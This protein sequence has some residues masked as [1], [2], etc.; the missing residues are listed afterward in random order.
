MSCVATLP[1]YYYL[2]YD[3]PAN[4]C[5]VIM[6]SRS[7]AAS[8]HCCNRVTKMHARRP[9]PHARR[10][11]S[12]S[13]FGRQARGKGRSTDARQKGLSFPVKVEIQSLS[14][15]RRN[16]IGPECR[17]HGIGTGGR[18]RILLSSK[19]MRQVF[20]HL[21]FSKDPKDLVGQGRWVCGD[22]QQM[23]ASTQQTDET[24]VSMSI[25]ICLIGTN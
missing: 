15:F 10:A 21:Q 25:S 23:L 4:R 22:S 19:Y 14:I 18:A 2:L 6:D 3:L 7:D 11:H 9:M 8:L 24:S 17:S 12:S 20:R 1:V 16:F 5:Q 13:E